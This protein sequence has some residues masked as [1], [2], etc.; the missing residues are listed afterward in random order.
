[1]GTVCLGGEKAH[2]S[3]ALTK[4][5]EDADTQDGDN[6]HP[7]IAFGLAHPS[8]QQHSN[9]PKQWKDLNASLKQL[10]PPHEQYTYI[11]E[12]YQESSESQEDAPHFS[13]TIRVN[14]Q[15]ENEAR[16]WI[17]EMSNHSKCTYRV[18]KTVKPS[19]KRV[20]CKLVMHCQHYAKK[21]T[22]KQREKSALARVKKARAPLC[23]Q[24]RNKKTDCPSKFVLTVQIP[25]KIQ[26]RLSE[27]NP[28]L[29][30]HCGVFKVEFNHN[31]PVHAAHT[32][33]FRDV[34]EHTKEKLHGLFEMG[35]NASSARHAHEQQLIVQA[36][37]PEDQQ[38]ILAD[39]AQNPNPQDM[40]RLY[41]KW[42]VGTYGEEN[43]KTMIQKL[44]E[45]VDEYNE[46]YSKDGGKA[47][48]QW[49]DAGADD[50]E[51]ESD[52]EDSEP[53]K[54]KRKKAVNS[55]PLILALCTPLMSRAHQFVQQ[56]S[57]IV[58]CDATSSLDRYNTSLF[59]LSTTT[60]AGAVPL[61]AILTS[62]E[63]ETTIAQGLQML[64][65]I[66]PQNAFFGEGSERGPSMIMTDDSSPERDALSKA[67]PSAT[68]LLCTFHF[69]QRRWTWLWD[70]KNGVH[71]KEE[72]SFLIKQLKV[73]VYAETEELLIHQYSAAQKCPV[74]NKYPNYLQHIQALWP[75]R[76]EWAHCYR[77]HILIRGNH[78]NNFA[79]AGM[80]IL[81]EIV[82][83]RVKAYNSVQ[84]FH[85]VTETLESYYCRKMLS[86][87]NNRLDTYVALRFQGLNAK[88]VP[89]D[90]I[91][92]VDTGKFYHVK[93]TSQRGVVYAVDMMVGVCTCP[94]GIDGSPCTHQAAIAI[95]YGTPSIN[96]IPT[97]APQIRRIY[98]QIALGEKAVTSISFY[99]GI[100]DHIEDIKKNEENDQCMH[101][102]F[103]TAAWDLIRAGSKDMS[104]SD[105]GTSS[106]TVQ[107]RDVA[108]IGNMCAAIDSI[109][110][111]LKQK[112]R[113]EDNEQL[114]FGSEKFIS[115]YNKLKHSL[116]LLTS[117]L[118]RFGWTYSGSVT[119]RKGGKVR[120]GRRIPVQATAAGRRR[121]GLSRGKAKVT[122]GKPLGKQKGQPPA[123][124]VQESRYILPTRR[125]PK[126]KR[127]HSLKLSIEKGHQNAGKW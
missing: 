94:Q 92:E 29:L 39:R 43:G 9:M 71:N 68:L 66:L 67:W 72:R 10:L 98:A 2:S 69:L 108:S 78:T 6:V 59:L 7:S 106:S 109:A 32:L 85:F 113:E 54:K 42:R 110:D 36:E 55:T 16:D 21:L 125:E 1:M 47:L 19:M 122:P 45:A 51:S 22:Q 8:L 88:K 105:N 82:F 11:I 14:L 4:Q 74:T 73:L 38:S 35:H 13:A 104:D 63:K 75:R 97:L 123:K 89:K 100:H 26:T 127:K 49:Y 44:Q 15:N 18:T 50:E 40:F 24:L 79:E 41:D 52:A 62:D 96:C 64:K 70:A 34:S 37:S 77:K 31:H 120:H 23:L 117:A 99:A 111:D 58:F 93:S 28:H 80:K 118:H 103:S 107:S 115:R 119:S 114:V 84:L 46:Q 3:K 86:V 116:P 56:S 81:K 53:P 126:G 90:S 57:D 25:T 30:T 76:Q 5:G 17:T 112:L 101:P 60:P 20:K 121:K 61:G 124:M 95:H 87:S 65:S 33:S 83:S 91:E 12:T 48:L 102:D 27:S